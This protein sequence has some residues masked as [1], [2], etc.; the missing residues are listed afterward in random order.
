MANDFHGFGV[1]GTANDADTNSWG[2][3][4]QDTGVSF[5]ELYDRLHLMRVTPQLVYDK[6]GQGR[7][8]PANSGVKQNFAFRYSNLAPANTPLTEGVLPT[9]SSIVRERVSYNVDQYGAYVTYTD[10]LDLFDVD[11]IKSQF[12][13]ILGDQAAI[14]S[15][16]IVRDVINQGTN[17]VYA[18]GAAD[19]AALITAGDLAIA[20]GLTTANDL[21]LAILKLKNAGAK[22][23][24]SVITGSTKIGTTPIRSAYYAFVHPNVV[25]DLRNISGFKNVEEYAYSDKIVEGEVGSYGDIRFIETDNGA[26]FTKAATS[27]VYSILVCGKDAYA[28]VSVRGKGGTQMVFKPLSSGG[29]SNALNQVGSIGWKMY[30]G[31]AI[32]NDAFMVRVE[33]MVTNDITTNIGGQDITTIAYT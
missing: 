4:E 25:D 18:N 17:V 10:Q 29:V 12:T 1:T 3:T 23:Y 33:T 6:F 7:F 9:K 8:I 28:N 5:A 19:R 11:N 14:T 21:K 27:N 16:V 30:A 22:K 32:L 20:D 13:D 31:A 26:I 15:D 24:T 2:T